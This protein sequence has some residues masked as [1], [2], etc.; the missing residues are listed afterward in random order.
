MPMNLGWSDISIRLLC[1]I[2]AGAW[3]GYN[4]GEHGR[5]A[6]LRTTMLVAVA[7]MLVYD[8]SELSIVHGR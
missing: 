1:T 2:V 5:P 8:W 3:I 6:G 7:R 4:R